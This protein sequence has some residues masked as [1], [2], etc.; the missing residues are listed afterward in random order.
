MKEAGIKFCIA[1]G[2]SGANARDLPYQAGMAGAYGLAKDEAL[3]AV[4]I[5]PAEILGIGDKMGSIDIGKVAN[6]VVTD[7]DLLDART[8]IKY[9]FID[10]RLL[11]LTSRHTELYEAFK[12]RK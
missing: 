5:Y 6:L 9:L 11:P 12:N 10:G 1:T 4:T 8:N 2:D 3:K 7:G